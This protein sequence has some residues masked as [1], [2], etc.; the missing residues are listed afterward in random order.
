MGRSVWTFLVRSKKE[1][2]IVKKLR[3]DHD[4]LVKSGSQDV[5]EEL[6]TYYAMSWKGHK[7]IN[8]GNCGGGSLTSKWIENNKPKTMLVLWPFAKPRG[9]RECQNISDDVDISKLPDETPEDKK[10]PFPLSSPPQDDPREQIFRALKEQ[11]G[12]NV[13]AGF[14]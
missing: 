3:E 14:K 13:I 2:E 10:L 9:W 1:L 5:G 12:D 8:L 6:C 11:F 7:W 4:N